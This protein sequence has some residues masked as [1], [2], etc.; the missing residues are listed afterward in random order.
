MTA[1]KL[2]ETDSTDFCATHGYPAN[3]DGWT[4]NPDGNTL[5]VLTAG[6]NAIGDC[7]VISQ[8]GYL[9]QCFW[10]VTNQIHAF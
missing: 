9:T 1:T 4:A 5:T 10:T 7:H 3:F 8:H 6:P 2:F